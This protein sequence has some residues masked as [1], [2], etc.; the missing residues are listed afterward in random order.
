MPTRTRRTTKPAAPVETDLDD[1]LEDLD[2]EPEPKPVRKTRKTSAPK[3][4]RTV[5]DEDESKPSRSKIEYGTQWL[6]ELVNER[7]DTDYDDKAVRIFLRKMV[8]NE[9]L[10][11]FEG[12]YSFKGPNDRL[13]SRIIKFIG[14]QEKAEPAPAKSPL[15]KATKPVARRRNLKSVS[16]P[17]IDAPDDDDLE[18]L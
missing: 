14:S 13:V 10:E 9:I 3:T 11:P 18:D 15:K 6:V 2:P 1:D 5:E 17:D 8:A 16:E 12:R 4:S 7:L